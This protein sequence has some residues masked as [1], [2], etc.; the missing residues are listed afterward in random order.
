MYYATWIIH[1]WHILTA[2]TFFLPD[3][4]I[5]MLITISSGLLDKGAEQGPGK[6]GKIGKPCYI[7]ILIN[8]ISIIISQN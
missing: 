7:L 4:I 3:Y 6:I 8:L 1:W 2:F 5:Y